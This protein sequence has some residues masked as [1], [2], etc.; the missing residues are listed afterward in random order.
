ML[1]RLVYQGSHLQR[2]Y[3]SAS[4]V[5]VIFVPVS[6]VRTSSRLFDI[7][8]NEYE[9]VSKATLDSL[10]EYF[11]IILENNENADVNLSD[12]VLTVR[13]GGG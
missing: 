1:R 6:Q 3:R 2:I 4:V 9:K 13:L 8:A 5:G 12:G 11:K 10:C 7:S